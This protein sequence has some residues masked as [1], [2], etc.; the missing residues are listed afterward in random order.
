MRI[1][2][3]QLPL[4][5][6]QALAAADAEAAER[7]PRPAL[8]LADQRGVPEHVGASRGAGGGHAG[9]RGLGDRRRPGRR[10]P[11]RQAG[12][13]E[14]PH[15]DGTVEVGYAIDPAY[16]LRGLA[17]AA[18]AVLLD[19]ARE[20]PEVTQVL[21]SV[22]PWNTPSLRLVRARGFVVIGEQEDEEDGLEI[23]H[24]LD[25]TARPTGASDTRLV[26]LRGNSGSGK[27]TVARALQRLRPR[28]LAWVGQDLLRRDVLRAQ[29]LPGT[30]TVDL[31]D[32]TA[33]LALDRACT[34]WW[35]A[36][37]ARTST[38]PCSAAWSATMSVRRR[39]TCGTCR[40]RRPCAGTRPSRSPTTS[41]RPSC[42]SGTTRAT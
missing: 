18:L 9:G 24:A 8:A 27:S 13:H 39:R 32:A 41:A 26:V 42:R 1:T 4:P 15:A 5:A 22:G 19:R 11:R 12:F 40:S 35:T 36:S 10:D 37:S 16:R 2:I 17:R 30:V 21:A 3:A 33:R 14:A 28:D 38:A 20:A 7:L 31:I 25:V 23:I 29:D 34:S 6:L